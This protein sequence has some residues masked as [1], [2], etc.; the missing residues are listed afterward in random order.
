LPTVA[1][2]KTPDAGNPPAVNYGH[3]SASIEAN[4]KSSGGVF[5]AGL[6]DAINQIF[7]EFAFAYHNQYHKA[8]PDGESVSIAKEYWLSCLAEFSPVQIARAAR[9]L[10]KS[11]EFLPTVSAVVKA[12]QS[13]VDLFGLPNVRQAYFEACRATSPKSAYQWSHDAVYHAGKASDWFVLATEPESVAF[14][15]FEY[16]YQ[17]MCQRVMQGESL[18]IE[19]P[20]ALEQTLGRELT[21]QE[22]HQRMIELRK[23]VGI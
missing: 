13:G 3:E 7:S 16:S 17:L 10:V 18:D 9:Q 15:A 12:C 19:Q 23:E 14:P 8:F 1:G 6:I 2:Q 11:S 22:R 21:P 20:Q 5:E 4:N